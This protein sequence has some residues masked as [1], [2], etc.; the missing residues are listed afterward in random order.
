MK[1]IDHIAINEQEE[2]L[3]ECVEEVQAVPDT[4]PRKRTARR[5]DVNDVKD[6]HQYRHVMAQED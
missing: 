3:F 2:I 4:A 5:R 1:N 6:V